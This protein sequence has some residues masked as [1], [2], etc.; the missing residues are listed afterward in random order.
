M[1]EL[2]MTGPEKM[3]EYHPRYPEKMSESSLVA[4]PNED[5]GSPCQATVPAAK[6]LLPDGDVDLAEVD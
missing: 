4:P 6:R 2:N 5:D 3:S 1:S